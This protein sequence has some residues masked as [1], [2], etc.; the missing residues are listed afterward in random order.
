[1]TQK[2]LNR[3]V[4]EQVALGKTP[5]LV[6]NMLGIPPEYMYRK[7]ARDDEDHEEEKE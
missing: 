1:M 4:T 6:A 5:E 7:M 2:D 3:F